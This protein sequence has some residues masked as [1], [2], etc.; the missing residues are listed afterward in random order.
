[1]SKKKLGL[2][3]C[4][5]QLLW[6]YRTLLYNLPLDHKV[7]RNF[8]GGRVFFPYSHFWDADYKIETVMRVHGAI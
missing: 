8:S 6:R 2:A 4:Q 7:A 3:S 5:T 1:M